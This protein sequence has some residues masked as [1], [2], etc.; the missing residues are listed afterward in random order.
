MRVGYM[1]RSTCMDNVTYEYML[2]AKQRLGKH[3]PM[4]RTRAT[5]G[6]PLLGNGPVNTPP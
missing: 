1:Q 2:I 5:K 3:I 6:R 4:K